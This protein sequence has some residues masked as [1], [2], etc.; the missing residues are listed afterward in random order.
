MHLSAYQTVNVTQIIFCVSD[1]FHVRLQKYASNGGNRFHCIA[2]SRPS[3]LEMNRIFA[4]SLLCSEEE[5]FTAGSARKAVRSNWHAVSY[6]N[7][8]QFW[9]VKFWKI[10]ESLGQWKSWKWRNSRSSRNHSWKWRNSGRSRNHLEN[11]YCGKRRNWDEFGA[12]ALYIRDRKYYLFSWAQ[13]R[14]G[15]YLIRYRWHMFKS[16]FWKI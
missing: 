7:G 10:K 8:V 14:N 11:G 2:A 9:S 6:G 4:R 5:H 3:V 16:G 12:N 13:L 1:L 15:R